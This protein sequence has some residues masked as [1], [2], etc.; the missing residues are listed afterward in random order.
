MNKKKKKKKKKKQ[1]KQKKLESKT[2]GN[3]RLPYMQVRCQLF[4]VLRP[5]DRNWLCFG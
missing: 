4:C 5:N 2:S 1:K 3:P